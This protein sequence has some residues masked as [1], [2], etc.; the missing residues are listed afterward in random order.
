MECSLIH[1]HA[2]MHVGTHAHTDTSRD[3]ETHT[4]T[5][6]HTQ[7][8]ISTNTHFRFLTQYAKNSP[9]D[10]LSFLRKINK[11]ESIRRLQDKKHLISVSVTS[12]ALE[13]RVRIDGPFPCVVLMP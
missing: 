3:T 9:F 13:S 11:G 12:A 5:L 4:L 8:D 1:S 7:V 6:V 2:Q 10:R